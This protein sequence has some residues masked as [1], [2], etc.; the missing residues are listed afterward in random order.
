MKLLI[1]R[2]SSASVDIGG[3]HVAEIGPGLLV[4]V[5]FGRQD[6]SGILPKAIDKLV[7]LRVFA[8]ARGRFQYSLLEQRKSVLAVPQFTLYGN[9]DSGRRPDFLPAM[10]PK[11]AEQLFG[12]FC[13]LL[14]KQVL[15]EAEFGVFGAHME[16]ALVNDGPV[17]LMIEL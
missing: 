1:Q 5:G 12:R 13:E 16:V 3:S 11:M 15:A 14:G 8:D 10:A 2:V 4:L 17:T 9:T 6:S 7:N